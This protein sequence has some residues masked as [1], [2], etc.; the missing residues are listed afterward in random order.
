VPPNR[1][2]E[3][4]S[5]LRIWEEIVSTIAVATGQ[6]RSAVT[7]LGLD[8]PVFEGPLQHW[9]KDYRQELLVLRDL[10]NAV[11]H[12]PDQLTNKQI[13]DGLRLAE[14]LADSL[15]AAT[16]VYPSP[17]GDHEPPTSWR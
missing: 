8:S 4:A 10:R 9:L 11:A 12:K 5:L 17:D 15:T 6:S 13:S 2:V 7:A 16:A 14:T 3:E 1:A